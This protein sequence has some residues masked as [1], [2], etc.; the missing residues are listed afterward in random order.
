MSKHVY[1]YIHLYTY[2]FLLISIYTENNR[3]QHIFSWNWQ[4]HR[5]SWCLHVKIRWKTQFVFW[6][7]PFT[8]QV[9][10]KI[11]WNPPSVLV[12]STCSIIF[13]F[14]RGSPPFWCSKI[15]VKNR[16]L[17]VKPTLKTP[18]LSLGLLFAAH[19]IHRLRPLCG[20]CW[21]HR[22]HREPR[23]H[24]APSTAQWAFGAAAMGSTASHGKCDLERPKCADG[25]WD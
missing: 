12:K 6:N 18:V 7:P 24:L 21:W 17:L 15:P 11:P 22:L 19:Q 23:W 1:D 16:L 14:Y 20:L 5:F 2:M 8:S 3:T 4:T 13:R 10:P 25:P 9:H